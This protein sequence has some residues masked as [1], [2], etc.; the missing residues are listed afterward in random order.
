MSPHCMNTEGDS[1]LI[2]DP[3]ALLPPRTR[4]MSLQ[5]LAM[6]TAQRESLSSWFQRLSD[7]HCLSPKKL[8]RDFV[9]P[10]LGL[11]GGLELDQRDRSWR[12][13]FFS[14]LGEVPRRWTRILGGLTGVRGLARLTL[15]PLQG[16]IGQPGTASHT[17][18]WCP[19]CL[20]EDEQAG[21]PYGQL[22]WDI[23][24][25]QACPFHEIRLIGACGCDPEDRLHPLRVK[26]L[27]HLCEDCG[28]SLARE[29]G[30]S[31]EPA[32]PE[33]VHIAQKV[34]SLL[35]SAFFEGEGLATGNK[36]FRNLLR[37]ATHPDLA[38]SGAGLARVVGVSNSTMSGWLN[39]KHLPSLAQVIETAKRLGLSPEETLTGQGTAKF[40][41]RKAFNQKEKAREKEGRKP[42]NE[43]V[44]VQRMRT[45]MER[46]SQVE[47]PMSL[48]AMAQVIG[49]SARDLLRRQRALSLE[50]SKRHKAWKAE[51]AVERW[52]ARWER[53]NAVAAEVT[54]EGLRVSR[55]RLEERMGKERFF[56]LGSVLGLRR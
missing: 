26:H 17:K 10:R 1:L 47:P 50:I 42:N 15:L 40:I 51:R 12:T 43:P 36:G 41:V 31:F 24:L 18:R 37:A 35:G 22:L 3:E 32:T 7:Q 2:E 19:L 55:R 25:V 28:R 20:H 56:I 34:A 48:T 44:S 13:S 5:P 33:E 6:G 8:A 16:L 38:G 14:G 23:G 46:L 39:D 49:T 53:L 21:T 29:E 11:N 9:L 27:P 54:E 4:L 30:G 52:N 45:E